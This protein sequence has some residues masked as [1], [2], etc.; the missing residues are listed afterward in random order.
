M[1]DSVD[2]CIV[3]YQKRLNKLAASGEPFDLQFWMQSYA[4]DVISQITVR[5]PAAGTS[6]GT[7]LRPELTY[8]SYP[9]GSAC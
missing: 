4:F 1:E 5:S 3:L 2:E 6:P 8:T 7:F 9:R